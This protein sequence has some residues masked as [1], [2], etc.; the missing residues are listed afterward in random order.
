MRQYTG[1]LRAVVSTRT[2]NDVT[3]VNKE[4]TLPAK[5]ALDRKTCSTYA[6]QT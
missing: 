6:N 5:R 4:E 1:I 3:H 2:E